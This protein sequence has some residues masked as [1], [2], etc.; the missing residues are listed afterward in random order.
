MLRSN[1]PVNATVMIIADYPDAEDIRRQDTLSAS[2]GWELG[3]MLKEAGLDRSRCFCTTLLKDGFSEDLFAYTK[4]KLAE[5]DRYVLFPQPIGKMLGYL[6]HLDTAIEMLKKEIEAVKPSIIITLGDLPLLALF[7]LWGIGKWRGSML[8]YNGCRVLPTYH[9]RTL[10][11]QWDLRP[12]AVHDFRRAF[13]YQHQPWPTTDWKFA[14]RP[15]LTTVLDVLQHLYNQCEQGP[16]PIACDIETSAGHIAC[17]GF[18]WSTSEALC[19]PFM[20]IGKPEGYWSEAEEADIVYAIA[21]VLTH[22]NVRIKGQNFAFDAQYIFR[23]WQFIPNTPFDTMTTWHTLFPG[24]QKSLDFICSMHNKQYVFWKDD[25]KTIAADG[26]EEKHWRY[27]CEDCVRTFEAALS[28]EETAEKMGLTEQVRFQNNLFRPVL[29]MML[30]GVRV[31]R[32]LQKE[33]AKELRKTSEMLLKD[34]QYIVGYELNPKSPPQMVDLFYNQLALPKQQ[35]RGAKGPTCDTASLAKLCEREPLIRPLVDRIEN[36]RSC[37][38]F[39]GNFLVDK[40]DTDG[41]M[42]CSY[43]TSGTVTFRF[44]SSENVFGSGLNLQNIPKGDDA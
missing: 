5:D 13:N 7:N 19:I 2:S 20:S 17:I 15:S 32:E 31:D 23:S 21:K 30:R 12:V 22:P 27:N 28:L 36:W 9:P 6:P 38:V 25:G 35:K 29:K 34:I 16:T 40:R 43:N 8:E 41:R 39:L 10:F 33:Q 42:R 1:G 11:M 18:A 37:Q 26:D 3:K 24:M 44:S 14:V 4:K